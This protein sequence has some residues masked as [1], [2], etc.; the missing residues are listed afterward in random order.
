MSCIPGDMIRCNAH[1]LNLPI[2]DTSLKT[3]IPS[4]WN[5]CYDMMVLPL[6]PSCRSLRT[7]S[8]EVPTIYYLKERAG[9][10]PLLSVLVQQV[11]IL[12]LN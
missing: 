3:D 2:Q 6:P 8:Y 11:F 12:F 10:F 9:R 7:M 1:L 5:S 4:R